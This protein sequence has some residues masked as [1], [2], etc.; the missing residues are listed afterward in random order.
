[1]SPSR[2]RTLLLLALAGVVA[3]WLVVRA[4]ASN[5][6]SMPLPVTAL[7]AMVVIAG[8]VLVF[9][10]PVRRWNRG[11][12]TRRL[13][14]LRAARTAVLAKASSH[15]GALLVGWYLGQAL[16]LVPDWAIEP[17]RER[18]LLAGVAVLCAGL[19]VAA[20]LVAERWCRLPDGDDDPDGEPGRPSLP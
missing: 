14:P 11:D 17:L 16:D 9:G 13:D 3:G 4:L 8:A 7:A 20:G 12:R 18:L 15:S 6:A 5:G 19:M 1:M 2:P 10:W